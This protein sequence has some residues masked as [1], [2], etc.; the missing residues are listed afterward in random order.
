MNPFLPDVKPGIV[1][2]VIRRVAVALQP[3]YVVS[4]FFRAAFAKII[5][6]MSVLPVCLPVKRVNSQL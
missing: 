6:N 1:V 2:P 5:G 4:V 3:L